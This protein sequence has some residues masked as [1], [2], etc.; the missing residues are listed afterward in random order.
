MRDAIEME[1]AGIP[2]VTICHEGLTGSVESMKRLSGMPDYKYVVVNYPHIP[3]C[4]W[5]AEEVQ[6]V[7]K[8]VAPQVAA[9][10][11]KNGE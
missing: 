1:M 8:Q 7:A 10:L 3:T 11:T 6:E 9:L 2:S 5:S 4:R